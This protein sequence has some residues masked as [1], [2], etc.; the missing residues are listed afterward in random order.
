[1]RVPDPVRNP[2]F[3]HLPDYP[4]P[5]LRALL[6]GVEPGADPID[7]SIGEP[8]HG[9]PAFITDILA[10]DPDLYGRYPPIQGTPDWR[11][12][13]AGWLTRRFGLP[14]G[15]VDPES[16]VLP[17]NGT[18]EGLYMLAQVAIPRD[19]AGGRATVLMPNPCYQVY[20]AAAL[21]M[22]AEPVYVPALP[23][24]NFMPRFADLPGDQLD[25]AAL[26]YIC[27]PANP[28][29]TV[30]SLEDLMD[31]IRLARARDM[32]LA[33][34]ECYSEIY[35]AVPPPG[36]LEACRAL[37]DAGE[38][39]ADNPF[40]RVLVF[41][42][43]SKRSNLPGLRSGFVAGDPDLIAQFARIRSYGGPA[44]PLPVYAAAAAAWSDETHVVAS[45]ALYQEKFDLA[46][47][48]LGGRF[49]FYRPAGGFFLWLDVG[50]SEAAALRLWREGGVRTLPGAYLGHADGTGLN[51]GA[52]YLRLALVEG[53]T[54]TEQ[55]L[56]RVGR[57]LNG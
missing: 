18:R 11:A 53:L 26:A 32:V 34:D 37:V 24:H 33:V 28:Q 51:P 17:L 38:G 2:R 9:V 39:V 13:V 21:S 22:D 20:A 6:G 50:D 7:L 52:P 31:M 57:I 29:G 5:R 1:M 55:A 46:A 30:A 27:S 14:D 47:E 49:G 42:S 12:A 35:D 16:H 43:L 15:W 54:A 41:H 8:R 23:A 44:S 40:D 45:R 19:K 56:R 4:F 25:R 3:D 36:A 10:R 48:I